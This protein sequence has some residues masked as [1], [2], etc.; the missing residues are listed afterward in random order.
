MNISDLN[1]LPSPCFVLDKAELEQNIIG[2]HKALE[3]NFNKSAVGYS[4]KT[5]ST[6]FCLSIAKT[7]GAYA[8]VVSHD[9]YKLAR[10]CG[11]MIDRIIY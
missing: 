7:L 3:V 6:P 8:E 1:H 5:N 9:E 10:A 4:I 11:F 2:F